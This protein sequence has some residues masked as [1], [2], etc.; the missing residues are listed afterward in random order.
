M[1]FIGLTKGINP[2]C[3]SGFSSGTGFSGIF[4]ILAEKF[5]DKVKEDLGAWVSF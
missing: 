1:T 4:T 2:F 3:V 5:L